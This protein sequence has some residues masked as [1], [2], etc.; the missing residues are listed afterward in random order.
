LH[1][2]LPS[3]AAL[4][5]KADLAI[6][7]A[8]ATS[9]ERLCLGLPALVVTLADNQRPIAQELHQRGLV[10]WLGD[11]ADITLSRMTTD[12]QQLVVQGL[13]PDWSENCRTLV[14]GK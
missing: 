9:W 4:M 6:G 3:L 8:G 1:N 7:S 5:V 12:L 13:L 10:R 2:P 14:D 11:A